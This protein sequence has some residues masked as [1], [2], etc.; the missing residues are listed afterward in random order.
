MAKTPPIIPYSTIQ[1][2]KNTSHPKTI[3][4]KAGYSH[5]I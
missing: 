2:Q 3:F 5:M 1:K 4:E